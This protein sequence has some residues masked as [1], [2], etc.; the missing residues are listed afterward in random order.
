MRSQWRL[1]GLQNGEWVPVNTGTKD[2]VY[3][4]SYPFLRN[5]TDSHF[6]RQTFVLWCVNILQR[7]V[8]L[9][10]WLVAGFSPRRP[11]FAPRSVHVGFVVDRVAVGQGFSRVLRFSPVYIIPQL[12]CIHSCII[13]GM[14]RW[15]QGPL[16]QW[17]ATGVPRH[18]GV[19][20]NFH[21]IIIIIIMR[22]IIVKIWTSIFKFKWLHM[23]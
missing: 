14:D 2:H 6:T 15:T 23:I 18:T 17:C 3:S 1:V 11:G 9:L 16:E 5:W 12:F 10:R 8:P 22:Q 7:A 13:W 21:L 4:T 20:R 19:P